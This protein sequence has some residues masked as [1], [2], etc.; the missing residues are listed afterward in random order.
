LHLKNPARFT[1]RRI[2]CCCVWGLG[3]GRRRAGRAAQDIVFLAFLTKKQGAAQP[4]H[5]SAIVHQRPLLFKKDALFQ[6][7]IK[8]IESAIMR[9]GPARITVI[10][11]LWWDGLVGGDGRTTIAQALRSQSGDNRKAWTPQRRRRALY[12]N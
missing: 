7:L 5:L 9:G 6:Y 11:R 2:F 8:V 3:R 12:C 10:R 4:R 1:A